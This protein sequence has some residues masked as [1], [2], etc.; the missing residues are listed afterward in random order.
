MPPWKY[1]GVIMEIQHVTSIAHDDAGHYVLTLGDGKNM[2]INDDI[3]ITV[4][5]SKEHSGLVV[6]IGAPQ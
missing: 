3:P 4:E 2:Y 6:V 1:G 5:P